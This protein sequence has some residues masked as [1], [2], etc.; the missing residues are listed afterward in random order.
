VSEILLRDWRAEDEAQIAALWAKVF[1]TPRGGQTPAWLFRDGP[2]GPAVRAVA[3]CAGRVVAHA[4]VAPLRFRLGG[5]IVRGGYSVGAM[6]DPAMQGRGLFVRVGRHLYQRLEEQGF[7]FVAGF[8]NRRSH[9]LMTGPLGRTPIGPFPWCVRPLLPGREAWRRRAGGTDDA[10]DAA[11]FATELELAGVR[12]A[13]AQPD[14]DRL[15]A[16]W[17]R[18]APTVTIGAV[19]DAG[20]AAWRYATRPDA[21]YEL[22]IA[23][24]ADGAAAGAL[25]LRMLTVRGLR[26]GFLVDLLVD[27]ADPRAGRALLRLAARRA[28]A[29][30]GVGL[31]ALLP[32]A[33][34]MR[35]ALLRAGFVRVPE[36]LHPQIIRF[37]VRGLGRW[38]SRPELADP[39]AWLLSWADTDVV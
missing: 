26:F 3:E 30:G 2:A 25:V 18:V 15:D 24:R 39:R 7:A 6:T 23:E 9:R 33:G 5:E 16:L 21:G 37:S 1:G 29:Q 22:W 11:A 28:R 32:G 19:R 14:D 31:S 13:C 36:R 38:A 34:P 10:P 8:S 17:A 20:F 12:L 4:G 35:R 27:P